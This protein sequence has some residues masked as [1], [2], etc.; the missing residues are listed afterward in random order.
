MKLASITAGTL[1]PYAD[2]VLAEL[3]VTTSF[4]LLLAPLYTASENVTI[5]I[6]GTS[7]GTLKSFSGPEMYENHQYGNPSIAPTSVDIA[8]D[9]GVFDFVLSAWAV[10]I[11]GAELER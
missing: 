11:W 4:Q 3:E 8:G 1:T 10:V 5:T 7:S 9:D 6:P 2:D